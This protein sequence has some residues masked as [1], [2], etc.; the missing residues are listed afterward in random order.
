MQNISLNRKRPSS[1]A[2]AALA[3]LGL[4]VVLAMQITTPGAQSQTVDDLVLIKT[5]VDGVHLIAPKGWDLKSGGGGTYIIA[6][7]SP[8][9]QNS[10]SAAIFMTER[11]LIQSVYQR[12]EKTAL[13]MLG[14]GPVL[15]SAGQSQ[16]PM[17]RWSIHQSNNG[18]RQMAIYLR[19]DPSKNMDVMVMLA[20][21]IGE[22][23]HVG[24]E[25]LV[26]AI[27]ESV[28][29]NPRKLSISPMLKGQSISAR[30]K[31]PTTY[32]LSDA[33]S[34]AVT[35][36]GA[37]TAGTSAADRLASTRDL[38]GSWALTSFNGRA[39]S[40]LSSGNMIDMSGSS[41][42]YQ[43][44]GNGTYKLNWRFGVTTG[45]L[46]TD[47]DVVERGSWKLANGRL[48]LKPDN[49]KGSMIIMSGHRHDV[50]A[51]NPPSRTYDALIAGDQIILRGNCAP[52][53]VEL[54]CENKAGRSEILDFPL[55]RN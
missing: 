33:E 12:F 11:G 44:V 51:R 6:D 15:R 26:K 37:R 19:S 42:S 54:E 27:G 28:T 46:M 45:L 49:Y 16:N 13:G 4:V 18:G 25:R 34:T 31:A 8:D 50:S 47:A 35:I 7:P 9:E 48:T 5:E 22:F 2:V 24:G 30:D 38:A 53:Q 32:I 21:P 41:V 17:A 39:S 55:S 10:L 40:D 23:Q 3:A 29:D 1:S 52:F 20:G 14:A 43:F 36:R